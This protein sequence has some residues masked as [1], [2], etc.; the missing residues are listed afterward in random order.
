MNI[1]R[2]IAFLLISLSL[3]LLVAC[4]P[5]HPIAPSESGSNVSSGPTQATIFVLPDGAPC[6]WAGEGATLAF[7]GKRVNYTCSKNAE[8]I[9]ALLG[10]P[11]PGAAGV[12]SVEK[13]TIKHDS[14]GFTLASSE[15]L[16]LLAATLDLADGTQCAFA[17]QGATLAFAGKRLNYT[18]GKPSTE[19][20]GILGDL[21]IGARGVITAEKVLIDRSASGSTVK[22]SSPVV[23]KQINGE[24][25]QPAR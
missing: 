13:A 3:L 6:R 4:Q 8:R 23:V 10:D 21:T 17:G 22:T 12:W 7:D 25:V 5:I 2:K 19:I 9:T 20:V 24:L 15:S 14:N 18:C 16:T 11:T 1:Q